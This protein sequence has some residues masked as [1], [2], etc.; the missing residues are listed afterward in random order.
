MYL[1]SIHAYVVKLAI[2]GEI[3][4]QKSRVELNE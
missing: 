1:S 3:A 4:I 2:P